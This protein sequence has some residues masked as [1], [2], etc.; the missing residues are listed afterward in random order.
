VLCVCVCVCVCV[1]TCA[2]VSPTGYSTHTSS[3]PSLSEFCGFSLEVGLGSMDMISLQKQADE[4]HL[5]PGESSGEDGHE[6]AHE[7]LTED[8]MVSFWTSISRGSTYQFK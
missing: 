5:L 8:I 3:L 2:C 7:V 4:D 1:C 6:A